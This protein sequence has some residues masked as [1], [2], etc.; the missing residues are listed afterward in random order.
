MITASRST[1]PCGFACRTRPRSRRPR[2]P[3]DP[4]PL[5]VALWSLR[6]RYWAWR[7]AA[8]DPLPTPDVQ[9]FAVYHESD[10][11]HAAPDS[12]GLQK[13]LLA[14]A[15]LFCGSDAAAGNSL[16]VTHELLHTLGATDKYD[17]RTGQPLAPQGLGDPEQSPLYPQ[18]SGEI[19]AGRIAQ[20]S[21]R[22]RD[23]RGPGADDG[24]PGDGPRD[25]V[26]QMS[27]PAT[28]VALA[29][30]RRDGERAGSRAR[31]GPRGD[32]S[33]RPRD[34]RAR[35]QRRRQEFAA[36]R[37]RWAPPAHRAEPSN[38]RVAGSTL[39]PRRE[40][41]R[42]VAFLAQASEDPFPGS[43]L[44][45]ALVGRHPHIDFWQWES[46]ADRG[47]ARR[48]LA[49]VDLAGFEE[50]DVETLSGG[51]R[52]RL[53]IA[54]ALTQEPR[55][56]ILDEPIQQL[57]PLHQLEVLRLFR[58]RA[59]AGACVVMSLHDPGIAAFYADESLLLFGDGR[60]LK[61]PTADVL[62]EESI[63]ALYGVAVRELAWDGGR[64]F[65]PA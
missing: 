51:E 60:W 6:L 63:G 26:A 16:V 65:V 25:R 13:G 1:S 30:Q 62:G 44:E 58:A 47:V 4:G 53:A 55:V 20:E 22:G 14:V 7:V 34:R 9:V 50:R 23:S 52:R 18:A 11:Q 29:C 35:P 43:V 42:H 21:S 5:D 19:M 48:C 33:S 8:D 39:W 36:A 31:R 24:R 32:L 57:D 37:A 12:T 49:A 40:L 28:R 17:R 45:T 54:A 15:H 10:G 64:T 61:G 59:D 2:C 3:T 41:A 46:E 56:Y 38:G 27:V